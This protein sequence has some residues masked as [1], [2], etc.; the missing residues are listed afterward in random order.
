MFLSSSHSCLAP[1]KLSLMFFGG[2]VL[3]I[4]MKSLLGSSWFQWSTSEQINKHKQKKEQKPSPLSQMYKTSVQCSKIFQQR[5]LK[6]SPLPTVFTLY[7]YVFQF[8]VYNAELS[9]HSNF[10]CFLSTSLL[11]N[12]TMNIENQLNFPSCTVSPKQILACPLHCSPRGTH[13][14]C[15][16]KHRKE[17]QRLRIPK[18]F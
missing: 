4:V 14:L 9:K 16:G 10:Y 11:N 13:R 6:F 3:K 18:P 15:L 2:C 17:S 1:S 7:F 5:K 8:G 12:K